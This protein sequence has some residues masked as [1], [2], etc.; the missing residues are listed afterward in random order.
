[1]PV[2]IKPV[3]PDYHKALGIPLKSGRLFDGDGLRRGT[4]RR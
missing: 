3:T 1:M 4:T 2:W